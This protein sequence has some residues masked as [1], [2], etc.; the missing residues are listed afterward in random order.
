MNYSIILLLLI[1][2]P[3]SSAVHQEQLSVDFHASM[4]TD[5]FTY[6]QQA[7]HADLLYFFKKLYEKNDPAYITVPENTPHIP[8]KFHWIWLGGEHPEL[9]QL[10]EKY[11][12]WQQTWLDAHPDWEYYVWTEADIETFAWHNRDL[13]NQAC[14]YG[15]KSDIWR[16]EI[17]EQE[18]GIYLDIDMVCL[19]PI[20]PFLNYDFFIGIQPLDTYRVQ[21]G[22]GII[23]SVTHHPILQHAIQQLPLQTAV[24][25][26]ARTGP[27]FFT[28]SFVACAGKDGFADIALPASF[29]YPC[30]YEQRL[31]DISVWQKPES[32]A[33]H[34]W[35]GSWLKP[36]AM[37]PAT[38]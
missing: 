26:V 25:I 32:Y 6:A 23:G 27:I 20:D 35:E 33:V 10:P 17:L 24:P 22:I 7:P 36:E 2:F 38:V 11:Q 30:G 3:L 37:V 28:R 19:K 5:L 12:A 29:F 31:L 4:Q 16:Y 34:M 1:F 14:N 13:F 9:H 8:K 21:L 15:Q 18:G